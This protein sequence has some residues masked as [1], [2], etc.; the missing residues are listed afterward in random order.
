MFTYLETYFKVFTEL[1]AAT[2]FAVQALVN[3]AV[4]LVGAVAA[5]VLMVTEQCLINTVSIV[6]G[7]RGVIAFLLCSMKERNE[8]KKEKNEAMS[9]GHRM[10]LTLCQSQEIISVTTVESAF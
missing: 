1:R 2:E 10:R 5:V 8:E 7:I 9:K 4:Q 3:K 6:A